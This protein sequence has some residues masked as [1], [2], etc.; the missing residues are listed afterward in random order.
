MDYSKL[1]L[2]DIVRKAPHIVDQIRDQMESSS[3]FDES[4]HIR[5]TSS[6]STRIKWERAKRRFRDGL[7]KIVARKVEKAEAHKEPSI[8]SAKERFLKRLGR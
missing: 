5:D 4:E 8:A 1:H 3:A 2:E 7:D 6:D